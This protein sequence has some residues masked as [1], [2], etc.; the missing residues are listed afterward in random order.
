MWKMMNYLVD[1]SSRL[2]AR[3]LFI[4]DP[5]RPSR[6]WNETSNSGVFKKKVIP[7]SPAP[8]GLVRTIPLYGVVVVDL[9]IKGI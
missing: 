3:G 2:E 5:N 1:R 8:L 4:A 7:A 6:N 9:L